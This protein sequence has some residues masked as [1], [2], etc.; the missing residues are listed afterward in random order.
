LNLKDYKKYPIASDACKCAESLGF[1][2]VTT[3]QQRMSNSEYNRIKGKPMYHTEPIF[4][5]IK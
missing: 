4:V 3:Y 1:R 2:L 5:W